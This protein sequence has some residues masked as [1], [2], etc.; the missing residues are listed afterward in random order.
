MLLASVSSLSF[1]SGHE[2]DSADAYSKDHRWSALLSR[3]H[4]RIWVIHVISNGPSDFR[5]SPIPDI[6]L[7]CIRLRGGRTTEVG[8]CQPDSAD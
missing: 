2:S 1:C 5:I 3:L 7:L 8:T 4:S 6:P